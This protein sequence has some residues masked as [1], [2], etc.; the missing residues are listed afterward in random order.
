MTGLKR[1]IGLEFQYKLKLEGVLEDLLDAAPISAYDS[2]SNTPAARTALLVN[3]QGC[4][5]ALGFSSKQFAYGVLELAIDALMNTPLAPSLPS[6]APLVNAKMLQVSREVGTEGEG[7]F[8]FMVAVDQV[9]ELL[10]QYVDGIGPILAVILGVGGSG[11]T[12][13]G[14]T[15]T[16]TGV[17]FRA[18]LDLADRP[19]PASYV[20][21]VVVG[22]ISSGVVTTI[23]SI[24]TPGDGFAIGRAAKLTINTS[25]PG[26][27]GGTGSG[28]TVIVTAVV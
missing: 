5:P 17:V 8:H 21:A 15:D 3:Y 25:S 9:L 12:T 1:L 13:D 4:A 22:N 18:S 2:G 28:G 7:D 16:A 27:S 26:Q 23:T 10:N 11:Y 6:V 14:S 19:D 24:T 20:Q